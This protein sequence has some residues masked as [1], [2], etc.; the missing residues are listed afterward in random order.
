LA[1]APAR[2]DEALPRIGG[3]QELA[4]YFRAHSR[5]DRS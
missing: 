4:L 3:D 1:E 5:T 2:R